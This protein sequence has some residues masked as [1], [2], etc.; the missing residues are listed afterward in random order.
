MNSCTFSPWKVSRPIKLNQTKWLTLCVFIFCMCVTVAALSEMWA[1][2]SC[3]H[4]IIFSFLLDTCTLYIYECSCS[5]F[6]SIPPSCASPSSSLPPSSLAFSFSDTEKPT[7]PSLSHAF[8]SPPPHTPL[9]HKY[10]SLHPSLVLLFSLYFFF[11]V[12]PPG[13]PRV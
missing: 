12:K 8:I 7:P 3:I 5:L 11:S 2:K 1:R 6:H 9:A 13:P 4:N 10:P